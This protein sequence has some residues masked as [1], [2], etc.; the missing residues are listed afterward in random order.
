MNKIQNA[1]CVTYMTKMKDACVD[2][3]I[4]DP[5]YFKVVNEKWDK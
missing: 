2:A 5:P 1:E 4:L 3:I